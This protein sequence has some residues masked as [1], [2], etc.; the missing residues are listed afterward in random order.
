MRG[1]YPAYTCTCARHY[2]NAVFTVTH[3][4]K[5]RGTSFQKT[6]ETVTMKRRNEYVAIDSL[7]AETDYRDRR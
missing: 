7:F 1:N 3:E 5:L 6:C 4:V 2:C